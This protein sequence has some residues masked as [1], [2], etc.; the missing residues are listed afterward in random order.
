MIKQD[1][2]KDKTTEERK[3]MMRRAQTARLITMCGYFIVFCS[4][5]VGVVLPYFGISLR[6][7]TNMTNASS[8]MPMQAYYIY[9]VNK[10]PIYEITF[11]TQ[12]ISLLLVGVAYSS[13]DNFLALLVLHVCGQLETLRTR[14]VLLDQNHFSDSLSYI[15]QDYRRLT[16]F[17]IFF[18][19]MLCCWLTFFLFMY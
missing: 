16:R 15:I 6:F 1:W 9:D 5:V 17:R 12:S 13:T 2:L 19:E 7:M 10:S 8:L 3:I 4:L 14:F 18:F 11:L